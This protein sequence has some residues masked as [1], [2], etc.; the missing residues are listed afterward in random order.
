MQEINMKKCV[1]GNATA[2]VYNFYFYFFLS[3]IFMFYEDKIIKG[4]RL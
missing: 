1:V 3:T 2:L 4:K